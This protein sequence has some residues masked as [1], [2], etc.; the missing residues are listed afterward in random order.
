MT[1]AVASS[2]FM[3]LSVPIAPAEIVIAHFVNALSRPVQIPINI[4][5]LRWR[6]VRM[7]VKTID[8]PLDTILFAP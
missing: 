6:R 2:F 1:S 7:V 8:F 5:Y 4:A 3:M